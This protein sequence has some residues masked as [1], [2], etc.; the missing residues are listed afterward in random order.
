MDAPLYAFES[1]EPPKARSMQ[2]MGMRTSGK[3]GASDAEEAG[4]GRGGRSPFR[5]AYA[6]PPYPG[7]AHYYEGQG[8][9]EEVDYVELCAK[10]DAEYDAWAVSLH[11][12]ALRKVLHL[13]PEK[14]RVGAWCKPWTP[15]KRSMRVQYTWEPVL[16]WTPRNETPKAG[17]DWSDADAPRDFC[18]ECS[19]M[20]TTIVNGTK[21]KGVKPLGFCLW[22]F[23]VLGVKPGESFTDVFPGSGAVTEAWRQYCA[24]PRLR[25]LNHEKTT[26]EKMI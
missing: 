17:D 11:T 16:F 9:A 12:P 7:L 25:T 4:S 26:Q 3:S 23:A 6:D 8:I 13:L 2:R 14:V 10:L 1:G 18:I 19:V 15:F 24:S 22:V 21:F 20:K 5:A